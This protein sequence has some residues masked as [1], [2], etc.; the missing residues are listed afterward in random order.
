MVQ[1]AVDRRSAVRVLGLAPYTEYRLQV[2]VISG[3]VEGQRS[4][5]VV[6]RTKAGRPDPPTIT[7]VRRSNSKIRPSSGRSSLRRH[8]AVGE[9]VLVRAHSRDGCQW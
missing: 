5:P 1:P 7:E 2:A 6:N 9:A 3:T 4:Q 8:M